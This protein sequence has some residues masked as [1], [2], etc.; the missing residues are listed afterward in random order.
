MTPQQAAN[1]A[2]ALGYPWIAMEREGTI[3]LFKKEP[4]LEKDQL[5]RDYFTCRGS[6]SDY[7]R[8]TTPITYTGDW[9]ESKTK[10]VL[11]AK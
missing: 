7:T 6:F 9:R 4:H 2:A 11:D 10:G 1:H 3:L 8:I 5:G